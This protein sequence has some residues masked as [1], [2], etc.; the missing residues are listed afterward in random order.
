R[1]PLHVDDDEGCE[2]G[3]KVE[4]GHPEPEA[5]EIV[6]TPRKRT[7]EAQFGGEVAARPHVSARLAGWPRRLLADARAPPPT[8][9]AFLHRLARDPWRGLAAFVDREHALPVDHVRLGPSLARADARVGDYTNVT[10]I[11]LYLTAIV[12][13]S[14]LHLIRRDEALERI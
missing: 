1:P 14:E 12:A 10:S 8:D 13:A 6:P 4:G 7:W 9:P 5:S 11:G 2:L 3:A